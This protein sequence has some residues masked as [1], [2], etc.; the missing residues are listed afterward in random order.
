MIEFT[1]LISQF[2]HQGWVAI[3]IGDGHHV[4]KILSSPSTLIVGDMTGTIQA[5][6]TD[7]VQDVTRVVREGV[8]MAISEGPDGA[9]HPAPGLWPRKHPS[10]PKRRGEASG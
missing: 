4:T 6:G 1:K 5:I 8:S 10:R 9:V 2:P 3:I 7:G